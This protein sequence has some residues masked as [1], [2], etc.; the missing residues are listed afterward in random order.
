MCI[1]P[2]GEG[3]IRVTTG[4]SDIEVQ[5][6]GEAAAPSAW[7]APLSTRPGAR[8]SLGAARDWFAAQAAR[9]ADRWTLWTPVALGLGA[10]LY[11]VLPREP[12]A[13][14]ALICA[15]AV[16]GLL[17]L[18]ARHGGGRGVTAAVVLAACAPRGVRGAQPPPPP[19]EGPPPP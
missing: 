5:G 18:A 3:A 15:L 7:A 16:A 2:V 4:R 10:A 9:Q 1:E 19:G 17:V 12:Q 14:V 11:F 13:W 8:P 6:P